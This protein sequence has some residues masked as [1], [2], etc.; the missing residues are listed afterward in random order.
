MHSI[1]PGFDRL[2]GTSTHTLDS[3]ERNDFINF[4]TNSKKA[5]KCFRKIFECSFWFSKG[6][7]RDRRLRMRLMVMRVREGGLKNGERE[8]MPKWRSQIE[9]STRKSQQN[10][11]VISKESAHNENNR[12]WFNHQRQHH[13][14]IENGMLKRHFNDIQ[15]DIVILENSTVMGDAHIDWMTV[16]QQPLRS[17]ATMSSNSRMHKHQI[18]R[19]SYTDNGTVTQNPLTCD[20][21]I[22][23]QYT[24]HLNLASNTKSC[25]SV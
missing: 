14:W 1:S 18:C 2:S 13:R 23:Q 25:I 7:E 24:G 21:H 16:F 4:F 17:I 6:C 15:N 20:S 22:E 19:R 11:Q 9:K 3:R 5:S 10:F 8:R 12:S